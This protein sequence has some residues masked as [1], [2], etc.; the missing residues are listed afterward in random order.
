MRASIFKCNY[1]N[2]K[3]KPR[4]IEYAEFSSRK[5]V[6]H[7]LSYSKRERLASK[8]VCRRIVLLHNLYRISSKAFFTS[9]VYNFVI[10]TARDVNP[11]L[12]IYK[13]LTFY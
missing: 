11:F 2:Y 6:P 5:S 4:K 8:L 1:K 13:L 7:F 10:A 12:Y 9:V 3:N